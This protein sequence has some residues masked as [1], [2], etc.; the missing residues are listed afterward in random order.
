VE[1][2]VGVGGKVGCDTTVGTVGSATALLS[3]LNNYV[4][5]NALVDVETLSLTVGLQVKEEL[6][7]GLNGL[8]GP[9]AC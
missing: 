2:D 4:C 7:N 5:N 3:A 6:T 8:F 9:S 1:L